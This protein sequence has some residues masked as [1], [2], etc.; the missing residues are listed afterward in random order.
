MHDK[1]GCEMQEEGLQ[2]FLDYLRDLISKRAEEDYSALV[3]GEGELLLALSS[4]LLMCIEGMS[5]LAH[6][7][8]NCSEQVQIMWIG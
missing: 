8:C 2:S 5:R 6:P 3:E 7:S 1:V 4:L